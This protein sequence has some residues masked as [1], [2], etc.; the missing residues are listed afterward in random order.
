MAQIAQFHYS[1]MILKRNDFNFCALLIL[2]LRVEV[3]ESEI[4][5]LTWTFEGLIKKHNWNEAKEKRSVIDV[6]VI[7]SFSFLKYSNYSSYFLSLQFGL[8]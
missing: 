4:T 2:I 6:C 1:K 5:E 3:N 7:I 8:Q